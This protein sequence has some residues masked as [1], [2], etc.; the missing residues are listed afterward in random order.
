MIMQIV[1]EHCD[2]ALLFKRS[3]LEMF[4]LCLASTRVD[5]YEKSEPAFLGLLF[6][7]GVKIAADEVVLFLISVNRLQC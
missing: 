1:P 7:T 6:G 4:D 2:A 3:V 5:L